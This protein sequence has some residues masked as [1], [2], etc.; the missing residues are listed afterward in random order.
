MMQSTQLYRMQDTALSS[1][2]MQISCWEHLHSFVT[3]TSSFVSSCKDM[4]KP[5]EN[6]TAFVCT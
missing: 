1:S 4:I 6:E 2:N 5:D 3:V